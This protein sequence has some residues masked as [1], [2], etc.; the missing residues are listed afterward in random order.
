MT[1]AVVGCANRKN[2]HLTPELNP[3]TETLPFDIFIG[4]LNF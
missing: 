1:V 2:K 3:F 4:D